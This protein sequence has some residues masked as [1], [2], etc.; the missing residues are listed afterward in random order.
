MNHGADVDV[1]VG[2]F[3]LVWV[4]RFFHVLRVFLGVFN[5][6]YGFLGFLNMSYRFLGVLTS[7]IMKLLSALL[8]ILCVL[9]F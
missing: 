3:I 7:S 1:Q 2:S 8:L 9:R 5:M 6:S 4:S